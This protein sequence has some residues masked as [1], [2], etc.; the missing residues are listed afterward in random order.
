MVLALVFGEIAG[1]ILVGKA[2]GLLATLGLVA[3]GMVVGTAL[4]RK[5]GIATL[6]KV[7]AELAAGRAP[8]RSLAE[9]AVNALA[10]LLIILPGFLTDVTG[11][12]LLVPTIREAFWRLLSRRIAIRSIHVVQP[13]EADGVV[14]LG[15]DDYE[16]RTR[17]DTPW[18]I[19]RQ[20]EA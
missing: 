3:L 19:R 2:I 1:F 6:A 18:R 12:L 8:A 14:D 4:L 9:G 13:L 11:V 20:P 5:Q 16:R 7:R 15:R 10:A 17:P